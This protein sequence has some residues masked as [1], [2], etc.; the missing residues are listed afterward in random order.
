MPRYNWWGL[1]VRYPVSKS[2]AA[3]LSGRLSSRPFG[4]INKMLEEFRK[5]IGTQSYS[6]FLRMLKEIGPDARTHRISVV[7]AAMLRF[8][9]NKLPPDCEDRTLAQALV[10]LDEQPYLAAEQSEEYELLFDL[11]DEICRETG[12]HNLRESSRGALYNI[13][14]NAIA[15]YTGWYKMPWEDY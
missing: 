2:V 1:L 7:I 3:A 14:E 12:M 15:E 13:A 4:S 11:I 10:T 9:L 6:T 8:A 5:I